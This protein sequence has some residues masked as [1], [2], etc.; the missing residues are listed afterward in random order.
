M[1]MNPHVSP[2]E[3]RWRRLETWAALTVLIGSL[4]WMHLVGVVIDDGDDARHYFYG[5]P[6]TYIRAIGRVPNSPCYASMWA[7]GVNAIS[8][9]I[10]ALSVVG[11]ISGSSRRSRLL[12]SFSIGDLLALI[13]LVASL[14]ALQKLAPRN[15]WDIRSVWGYEI[16]T[17]MAFLPW[18]VQVSLVLA[19]GCACSQLFGLVTQAA[20]LIR[21]L[22]HD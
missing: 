6:L 4:A 18:L 17:A 22:S 11:T 3:S 1:P 2:A 13:T 9:I 15:L 8:G 7:L 5:W 19:V 20:R 16:N 21:G 10:L 14:L 12:R